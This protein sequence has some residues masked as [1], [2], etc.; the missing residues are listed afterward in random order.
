ML[1][2]N[3][4]QLHTG[5]CLKFLFFSTMYR[6]CTCQFFS[7][8]FTTSA[9]ERTIYSKLRKSFA[10]TSSILGPLFSKDKFTNSS[11]ED[12]IDDEMWG[13]SR[14]SFAINY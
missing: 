3:V 1:P 8:N 2:Y 5:H 14:R 6:K 4:Q 9:Q 11:L 13:D 10:I 12:D 7:N